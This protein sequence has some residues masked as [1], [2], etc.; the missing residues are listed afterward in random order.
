MHKI[1]KYRYLLILPL[2]TLSVLSGCKKWYGVPDDKDY[3]SEQI[4]FTTTTFSPVIGRLNLY[5]VFNADGSTQ[6]LSFQ[7]VN[8]RANDGT[9]DPV[10]K[11]TI[12]TPSND[13]TQAVPTLVWTGAYTGSEASVAEIEAKRHLENHPLFEARGGGQLI[14]WPSSTNTLVPRLQ[15]T[16]SVTAGYLFDVQVTNTGGTRTIKNLTI[17]PLRERPYEPSNRDIVTGTQTDSILP[18]VF[19]GMLGVTSRNLL[20]NNTANHGISS[21]VWVR[22]KRTG[23]GNS[24]TFKFLDANKNPINPALFNNTQWATLIH[25]FN[26]QMTSQYVRYDVAYP[27]PLVILPTKYTTK[28]GSQATA[29]FSYTRLGF[30]GI[31]E[32]GNMGLNFNIYRQGDWEID[33]QFRTE[34]PRFQDEF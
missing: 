13:L 25:G 18:S 31:R 20:A 24:L 7:I 9:V 15:A 29:L 27:I 22:F 11:A 3:L 19:N 21:S 23:D 12:G 16:G 8:V 17:N 2:V 33:F 14:L 5:S 26:M 4:N 30:N 10:T 32:T 28:D 34:T 6:P 1:Y